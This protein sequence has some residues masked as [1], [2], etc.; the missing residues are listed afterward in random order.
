MTLVDYYYVFLFLNSSFDN[1]AIVYY[2]IYYYYPWEN[3]YGN[4]TYNK[5]VIYGSNWIGEA[6]EFF[7]FTHRELRDIIVDKVIPIS[8][9][10]LVLVSNAYFLLSFCLV[11]ELKKCNFLLVA[12]QSVCDIVSVAVADS[13]FY[14]LR[15]SNIWQRLIAETDSAFL[16]ELDLAIFCYI[17]G[18]AQIIN[19]Y[20]TSLVFF[21]FAVER[22]I[23]V[24]LPFRAKSILTKSFYIRT[25]LGIV[26]VDLSLWIAHLVAIIVDHEPC[27]WKSAKVSFY[28]NE[29]MKFWADLL[30]FFVT[31]A[32][33]C[34]VA[35]SVICV[36]F[37]KN[38]LKQT[39][40]KNNRNVTLTLCFF[41]NTFAWIILASLYSFSKYYQIFLLEWSQW[42]WSYFELILSY[43]NKHL[44]GAISVINPV[45]FLIVN[46]KFRKPLHSILAK[47]RKIFSPSL[48]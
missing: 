48:Q 3:Q 19:E 22:F 15:R 46:R 8:M 7:V 13:L 42:D 25:F 12:W 18:F 35:Y 38:N 47:C 28:Y 40:S 16:I 14:V 23:L 43:L 33:V 24:V 27:G 21:F 10:A 34:I 29:T 11:K 32:L 41:V 5:T 1:G 45:V 9:A 26:L 2:K 4:E 20:S 17:S 44:L 30:V 37:C 39:A 36:E 31:P 6:F